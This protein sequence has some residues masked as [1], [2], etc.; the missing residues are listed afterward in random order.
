MGR[1]TNDR[2]IERQ[3]E[4]KKAGQIDKW[5]ERKH[6]RKER[7]TE[8][9]MDQKTDGQRDKQKDKLT[10]KQGDRWKE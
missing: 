9:Q 8:R 4:K 5:T 10:G 3:L 1:L 7:W 6:A 2:W